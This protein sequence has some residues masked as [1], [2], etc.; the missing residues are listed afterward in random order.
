MTG[1]IESSIQHSVATIQRLIY[2]L[3]TFT[4]GDDIERANINTLWNELE[5]LLIMLA[6]QNDTADIEYMAARY[7]LITAIVSAPTPETGPKET[8]D[9][10][11]DEAS[12]RGD[13]DRGSDQS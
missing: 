13:R 12:G 8:P 1:E 2:E 3:K 7:R 4:R 6:T 10:D 5:D 9:A 11:S